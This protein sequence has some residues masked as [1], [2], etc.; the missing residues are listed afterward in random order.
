[1]EVLFIF[2]KCILSPAHPPKRSF[3]IWYKKKVKLARFLLPWADNSH[4][5]NWSFRNYRS[6][7]ITRNCEHWRF[8]SP[9][10]S[11]R[12]RR[13]WVARDFFSKIQEIEHNECKDIRRVI[14]S[15]RSNIAAT[16]KSS[17]SL[18]ECIVWKTKFVKIQLSTLPLWPFS[19][20]VWMA[21]FVG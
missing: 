5:M 15:R 14:T 21:K 7:L 20:N 17:S 8:R 18:R 4:G 12:I 2:W 3:H 1:M 6:K 19:W 11:R 9:K 16:N 13:S 10:C